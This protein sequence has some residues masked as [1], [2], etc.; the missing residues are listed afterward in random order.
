MEKPFLH[1]LTQP[2]EGPY[3]IRYE[4]ELKNE[5]HGCIMGAA[6]TNSAKNYPEVSL[7]NFVFQSK[8]LIRC[9]LFQ[10]GDGNKKRRYPHC[11]SISQRINK[12]RRNSPIDIEVTVDSNFTAV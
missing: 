10:V 4:S 6:K 3:R 1:I 7:K 12:T 8:V 5:N 2:L 11:N 9:S